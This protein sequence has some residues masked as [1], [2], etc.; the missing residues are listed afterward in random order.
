MAVKPFSYIRDKIRGDYYQVKDPEATRNIGDL[1]RLITTAKNSLVA[2]INEIAGQ[3]G[4]A[5]PY[6]QNPAD[7]GTASPGISDKYARGDHVHKKPTYSK[8][9]VGLDNVDNVRQY[10]ASNPPPYPVSSVDGKTG[11]VN[12]LP[13]GGTTGQVLKKS[14]NANYA[15][16]WT[17][18]SGGSTEIYWVTYGTTT[19]SEIFDALLAN[20]FLICNYN[21]HVYIFSE[22]KLISQEVLFE[23]IFTATEADGTIRWIKYNMET[24]AWSEGRT[25]A[26]G[27]YE[28]IIN[29][30]TSQEVSSVNVG[31]DAT[32]R[33]KILNAKEILMVNYFVPT[34]DS[35]K[36]SKGKLTQRLSGSEVYSFFLRPD[37]LAGSIVPAY[38]QPNNMPRIVHFQK[39]SPVEWNPAARNACAYIKHTGYSNSNSPNIST[40]QSWTWEQSN[41]TYGNTMDRMVVETDT[42]FGIGSNF[43]LYVR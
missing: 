43:R 30:T 40:S 39:V 10:S 15:V 7:L 41:I 13:S 34:T 31:F 3:G 5:S 37:Y 20:K 42:L 19:D 1:S 18:E 12:I 28:Q 14:S 16:E 27:T 23:F 24:S 6:D 29:F 8:S 33:Q 4:G 17:D 11:A 26:E 22:M 25:L 32:A 35:S 38:G 9:D 21:S 2:A 36:T